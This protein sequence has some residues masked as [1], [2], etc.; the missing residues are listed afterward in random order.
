MRRAMAEVNESNLKDATGGFRI[1]RLN[2]DKTRKLQGSD[3]EFEVYFE[4]SGIP[5]Q[6]WGTLFEG[7]WKVL[8]AW[9]PKLWQSASIDR[10]FLVMRCP[11]QDVL[12]MHL[13]FLKKAV[14]VT[15]WKHEQYVRELAMDRKRR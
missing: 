5:P 15:N 12:S 13:P 8:N 10:G 11:I 3:L 7:E 1:V 14:E 9:L 2:N 6:S 4:L